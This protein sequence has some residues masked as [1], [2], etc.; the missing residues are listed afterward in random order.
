MKN[1]INL[2]KPNINNDD[3]KSVNRTL[4]N[5]YL[6]GATKIVNEFEKKFSEKY[7]FPFALSTNSG[8]SALHLA[9][10]SL[11]VQKGDEVIIPSL[12]FISTANAVSY[13]GA[14][15]VIVDVDIDTYQISLDQIEKNI[16]KKTK[17]IMPVHLYGNAP[18]LE[19]IQNIANKFKL[20]VINDSAEALGT[21]FKNKQSG[22]YGDVSIYSF[23]PNKLITTGEGGMLVTK[24]KKVF[25]LAKRYRDQGLVKESNEYIHDIIGY[26]YRMNSLSAAIGISQLKKVDK[27]LKRK[28]NI[29]KK[30]K[31]EFDDYKVNFIKTEKDIFNSQWLTVI[32]FKDYEINVND[33]REY[34]FSNGIETKKIFYPLNKQKMYS[35]NKNACNNAYKIYDSSLC[36]PSYPDLSFKEIEYICGKIKKYLNYL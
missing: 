29:N 28:I 16:T 18:N 33:L 12:S 22:L 13:V 19:K 7:K 17:V 9:L 25:E 1:F 34:L 23:Y 10:L 21:K 32:N 26:N 11:G 30:Y 20:K 2:Y 14:K 5:S 3:I 35:K 6:S 8:T 36:L 31:N 15:P 27:L 24:S 4:N